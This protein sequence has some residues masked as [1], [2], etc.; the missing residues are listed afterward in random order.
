[1]NNLV[2]IINTRGKF[3]LSTPLDTV[4]NS[5]IIYTVIANRS[6]LEMINDGLDILNNVYLIMN[7][8]EDDYNVDLA[9][10]VIITVLQSENEDTYYIPSNKFISI[11]DITGKRYMQK[12]MAINLG[13]LPIDLNLD[14]LLPEVTDLIQSLLGITPN[15]SII[16]TSQVTLYTNEEHDLFT[17]ERLATITNNETCVGKLVKIQNILD[18]MRNKEKILVERLINLGG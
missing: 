17:A 8:T 18:E 16:D 9:N 6:I 4:L 13:Y 5:D 2:P 11:P 3:K 1:M 12:T 10:N 7:L 14:Y 15:A